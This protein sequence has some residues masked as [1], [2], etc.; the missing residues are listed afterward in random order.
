DQDT[1]LI[2][3]D[4]SVVPGR[5]IECITGAVLDLRTVVHL[6]DHA[7]FKD[8]AGVRRLTGRCSSNWLNMLRPAPS[9]FEYAP[10]KGV[11]ADCDNLKLPFSIFK[12]TRFVR[13]IKWFAFHLP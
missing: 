3:N 2:A 4:P 10:A 11:I 5:H 9:G 7:S 8:I 1:A 12:R 6:H 13:P